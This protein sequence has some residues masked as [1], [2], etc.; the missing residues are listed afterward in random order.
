MTI[1]GQ[2]TSTGNQLVPCWLAAAVRVELSEGDL[3][4][5]VAKTDGYSGSDMTHL[6]REVR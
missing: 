4:K 6:M 3:A 2:S 1:T 5:I